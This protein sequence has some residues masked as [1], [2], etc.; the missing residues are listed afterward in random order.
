M[1]SAGTLDVYYD[2]TIEGG[3][4]NETIELTDGIIIDNFR[5]LRNLAQDKVHNKMVRSQYD[6]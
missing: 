2:A 4:Y 1:A 5:A 6:N 3:T